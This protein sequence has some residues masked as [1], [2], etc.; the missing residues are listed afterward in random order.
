MPASELLEELKTLMREEARLSRAAKELRG[1]HFRVS[2]LEEEAE[3]LRTQVE[4][5]MVTTQIDARAIVEENRELRMLVRAAEQDAMMALQELS[6]VQA[7]AISAV[8]RVMSSEEEVEEDDGKDR[9]QGEEEE[10]VEEEE[11]TRHARF[12]F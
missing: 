3:S 10:V 4:D 6:R 2:R 5:A 9:N 8:R 1:R 7:Q 12:P 11:E